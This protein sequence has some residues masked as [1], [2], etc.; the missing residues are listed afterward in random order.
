MRPYHKIFD[1]WKG[2]MVILDESSDG[3]VTD[4]NIGGNIYTYI[5]VYSMC[6]I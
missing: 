2:V 3:A 5:G 6:N 4:A 1:E